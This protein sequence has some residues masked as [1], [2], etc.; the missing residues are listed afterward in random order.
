MKTYEPTVQYNSE[1]LYQMFKLSAS[2]PNS[3]RQPKSPLINRLIN[4]R[5][6]NA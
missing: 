1:T 6:L 5:L 4:D 3:C 2:C